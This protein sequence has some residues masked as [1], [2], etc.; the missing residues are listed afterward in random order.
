[1]HARASSVRRDAVLLRCSVMLR[2][3]LFLMRALCWRGVLGRAA[4][5]LLL[6]PGKLQPGKH[7]PVQGAE[8]GSCCVRR[9]GPGQ[10]RR[11]VEGASHAACTVEMASVSRP[12]ECAVVD[13]VQ[14]LGDPCRGHAFT[15]A[16]LGLPARQL[17]VCGDAAVLPLLRRIIADAGARSWVPAAASED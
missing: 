10:E 9:A 6:L 14:M 3:Q 8:R 16:V 4:R 2:C 15:R 1:M 11:V 5:P 17:H 7:A 13:E 12:V